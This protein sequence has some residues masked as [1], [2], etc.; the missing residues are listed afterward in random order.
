MVVGA[1]TKPQAAY[2]RDVK[3][4][5]VASALV[6]AVLAGGVALAPVAH[7]HAE[8]VSSDPVDGAALDAPPVSVSFTF[9][10]D[11]LP[12]F[13]RLIATGPSGDT[14]DL[15][16]NAVEGP[17]A[18]AD[19]PSAAEA[20]EWTVNYRVVSQDGHPIE[21]GITFT[22]AAPEPS[23]TAD[24]TSASPAPEPTSEPA[25]EPTREPAPTDTAISPS[26]VADVSSPGPSPLAIAAI[27]LVVLGA[28]GVVIAMFARRRQ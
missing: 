19:W 12:D 11:L 20:G 7:G 21:G 25:P 23:P 8:L 14:G 2:A 6:A 16:V 28:A 22:Y 17:T 4:S 24:P 26:P 27:G 10:E 13:V 1:A 18:R 9:N 15:V 3:R 5:L